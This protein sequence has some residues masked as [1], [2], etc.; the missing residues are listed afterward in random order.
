MAARKAA[1]QLIYGDYLNQHEGWEDALRE[2]MK[3]LKDTQS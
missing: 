2:A 1:E 3:K